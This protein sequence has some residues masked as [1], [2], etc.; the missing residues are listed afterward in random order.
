MPVPPPVIPESI[1]L[2]HS[3]GVVWFKSLDDVSGK[4]FKQLRK[5]SGVA[6][7][8]AI[9]EAAAGIFVVKWDIP[10]L[11]NLPLP[12]ADPHITDL[13]HWQDSRRLDNILNGVVAAMSMQEDDPGESLPDGV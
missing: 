5:A 3:G 9:Y 7:P 13:L 2:P 8:N 4:D 6:D 12:A 1:V 11:P 10:S